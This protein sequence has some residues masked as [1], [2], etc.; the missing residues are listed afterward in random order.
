[1]SYIL[2]AHGETGAPVSPPTVPSVQWVYI[3][4]MGWQGAERTLALPVKKRARAGAI[5]IRVVE[6]GEDFWIGQWALGV[7]PLRGR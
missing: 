7:R 4:T 3:P 2:L 6:L 5:S 1:M